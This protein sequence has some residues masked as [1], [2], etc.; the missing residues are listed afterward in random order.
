MEEIRAALSARCK[1]VGKQDPVR[2]AGVKW[3]R[4]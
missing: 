4:E 3:K 1:T 2:D